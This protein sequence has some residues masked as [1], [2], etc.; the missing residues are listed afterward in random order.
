LFFQEFDTATMRARTGYNRP[1]NLHFEQ[2]TPGEGGFFFLF[3]SF[4]FSF[5][6]PPFDRPLSA[7]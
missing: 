2:R 5:L 3:F 6:R 1:T 7:G 4:F